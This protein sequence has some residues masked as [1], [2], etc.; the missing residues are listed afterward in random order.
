[1]ERK[2]HNSTKRD[3]TVHTKCTPSMPP[4]ELHSIETFC[5]WLHDTFIATVPFGLSLRL[6]P[7]F[8]SSSAAMSPDNVILVRPHTGHV[9]LSLRVHGDFATSATAQASDDPASVHYAAATTTHATASV[10]QWQSPHACSGDADA[11]STMQRGSAPFSSTPAVCPPK[12]SFCGSDDGVAGRF[13][14]FLLQTF[15]QLT[16]SD[17]E[18]GAASMPF[19]GPAAVDG[20]GRKLCLYDTLLQH[21]ASWWASQLM[22]SGGAYRV[23]HTLPNRPRTPFLFFE[24]SVVAAPLAEPRGPSEHGGPWRRL[25]RVVRRL[26]QPRGWCL[27]GAALFWGGTASQDAAATTADTND[28]EDWLDAVVRQAVESDL[29]PSGDYASLLQTSGSSV[30]VSA[31]PAATV[32]A[33][34]PSRQRCFESVAPVA[35]TL[36]RAVLWHVLATEVDGNV[37]V[38]LH[39]LALEFVLSASASPVASS[40]DQGPRDT[41]GS[42]LVSLSGV[43]RALRRLV[44]APGLAFSCCPMPTAATEGPGASSSP[45]LPPVSGPLSSSRL[46]PPEVAVLTLADDSPSSSTASPRFFLHDVKAPITTNGSAVRRASLRVLLLRVDPE[47]CWLPVAE[48]VA[49]QRTFYASFQQQ[50][51]KDGR[52]HASW[53]A[54]PK[55]NACDSEAT[56]DNDADDSF[57]LR[58][59][60]SAGK[61]VVAGRPARL[62]E[63]ASPVPPSLSSLSLFSASADHSRNEDVTVS[64]LT[65]LIMRQPPFAHV[66]A[67]AIAADQ[68]VWCA[69]VRLYV[70]ALLHGVRVVLTPEKLPALTK[71]FGYRYLHQVHRALCG[72][73]R[74]TWG[75]EKKENKATYLALG[76]ENIDADTVALLTAACAREPPI[77][78]Y[79]V[80]QV[81]LAAFAHLQEKASQQQQ[82]SSQLHVGGGGPHHPQLPVTLCRDVLRLPMSHSGTSCTSA[83]TTAT[84]SQT[85]SNTESGDPL[86]HGVLHVTHCCMLSEEAVCRTW[87][88]CATALDADALMEACKGAE[89]E[90]LPSTRNL[91]LIAFAPSGFMGRTDTSTEEEGRRASDS[92]VKRNSGQCWPSILL[93]APTHVHA[94]YYVGLLRKAALA[95][96]DA[97]PDPSEGETDEATK[98]AALCS[99]SVRGVVRGGGAFYVA[100]AKQLRVL[101]LRLSSPAAS[102][103]TRTSTIA[104]GAGV[105][106]LSPQDCR[107]VCYVLYLLAEACGAVATRHADPVVEQGSNDTA[108]PCTWD[109]AL[110]ARA[111]G[112]LARRKLWLEALR[113]AVEGRS[114]SPARH[115]SSCAS[116]A[117]V[118]PTLHVRHADVNGNTF[119]RLRA[120]ETPR[121]VAMPEEEGPRTLHDIALHVFVSQRP[122]QGIGGGDTG[123]EAQ[124]SD[125]PLLEPLET[126]VRAVR[127]ALSLLFF[128]LSATL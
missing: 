97:L 82:P 1:M 54:Q 111:C 78:I 7:F 17:G 29:L 110:R 104:E 45:R 68:L 112:P 55:S 92:S 22:S 63:V 127:E 3:L 27:S 94:V 10:L 56:E 71:F 44:H 91:C 86:P 31:T 57:L 18:A 40:K 21:C 14:P 34:L 9:L 70:Y 35:M 114:F 11:A 39:R 51:K 126:N 13:Y 58:E 48:E 66:A 60:K 38:V 33:D 52:G 50:A 117:A 26:T 4:V 72:L 101:L 5:A 106:G 119:E 121:E 53:P 116:T 25:L 89:Q 30:T 124:G 28:G 98:Q 84:S 69:T 74:P 32:K 122:V 113:E 8:T 23:P 93:V 79:V 100:L 83:V 6:R 59:A 77:A 87:A 65:S 73:M 36:V 12:S 75:E 125:L 85:G 76:S 62:N 88:S 95:L 43:R 16:R 115:I 123:E 120:T 109:T 49:S 103:T 102:H 61:R 46:L 128:T 41:Q 96:L 118:T 42:S 90:F 80:D 108:P 19:L 37:L 2:Q 20:A 47:G 105:G 107:W 99:S 24:S 67:S 64:L 81:D 15:L